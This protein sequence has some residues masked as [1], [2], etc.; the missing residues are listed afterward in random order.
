MFSSRK[1]R[2]A[3]VFAAIVMA[4]SMVAVDHADARRAGGGGFGSRGSRT[5]QSAPAT[6]TAPR[7]AAPVERSMTPNAGPQ[8]GAASRNMGQQRPGFMNGFGGSLLRGLAIGG[9]I[10][11]LFGGGFGGMAGLLG[12]ILQIALIA[13]AIFLVMR[14]LRSRSNPA[15]AM[16]GGP[17]GGNS[18][19]RSSYEPQQNRGPAGGLGGGLGGLGAKL[20]AGR[21]T[22][23]PDEIGVTPQDLSTFERML[24]EI[25]GA[26][27]REDYA[28]LR[29]ATT[30]EMMSY[31]SEELGQ[32]ASNGV[33]NEVSD[34]RLLQG[35]VSE[36][37]REGQTE[38]ATVAMRYSSIDATRERA[39]GRVIDG[40]AENATESTEVW[41][42]TRQ[43]R[44]P[45]LLSAIQSA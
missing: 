44:G 32:N 18:M 40:D 27:G 43:G 45:W 5:F 25:Q 21:P 34:V 7:A 35:D 13:G 22:G 17:A 19:N 12:M 14:F 28:A 16:A 23:N 24:G 29:A 20:G 39:T 41:T 26:Y 37:W 1:L 30:P 15:P 2:F 9:L 4:F 10:G 3:G 8:T 38:Y 31:F 36:A 33:K 6:A 42:F 11:M